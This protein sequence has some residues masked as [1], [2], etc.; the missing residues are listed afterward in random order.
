MNDT[1]RYI[2]AIVL[3]MVILF[4]WQIIFP[5]EERVSPNNI[6]E[7]SPNL[8]PEE[9]KDKNFIRTVN[10]EICSSTPVI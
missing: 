5:V 2:V 7:N 10:Q 1:S 8:S 9:T 6:I 3:A 4:S